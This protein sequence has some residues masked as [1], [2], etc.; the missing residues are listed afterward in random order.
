MVNS[1][2][3]GCTPS[4]IPGVVALYNSLVENTDMNFDFYVLCSGGEPNDLEWCDLTSQMSGFNLVWD[5][6]LPNNPGGSGWGDGVTQ[7]VSM[8]NRI[9]IPDTFPDYERSIWLDCDTI[10]LS[11]ISELFNTDMESHSVACTLNG[12]PWNREK[13]CL[14]RDMEVWE[15]DYD[16]SD[17]NSPQ[18]GVIMFDTKKWIADNMTTKFIESTYNPKIKGKYV[19]QSYLGYILMGKFKKL[20]FEWN[21]DVSWLSMAK[22]RNMLS[23]PKILHYIGGGKKLPWRDQFAYS[24]SGVDYIRTWNHFYND[25][26]I[27]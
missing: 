7:N 26:E 1:V 2:I 25:G 13:Q 20:P 9:M 3:T 19:V 6:S 12:N 14:K 22:N 5:I 16:L 18:A 10:V 24:F 21:V 15:Y 27:V 8:Y 23:E 4:H 11:N 17:V